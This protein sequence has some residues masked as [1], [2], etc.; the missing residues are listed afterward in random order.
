MGLSL[1][2]KVGLLKLLSLAIE[3]QVKL[4]GEYS[5]FGSSVHVSQ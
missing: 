3:A 1:S 4:S 5:K 2:F